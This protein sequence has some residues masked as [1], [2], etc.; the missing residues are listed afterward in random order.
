MKREPLIGKHR[1]ILADPP[2]EY[3]RTR[4][5]KE[6]DSIEKVSSIKKLCSR[7]LHYHTMTLKEM[8]SMRSFI[9]RISMEDSFLFMWSTCPQLI[10]SLEL[11]KAWGYKYKTIAFVWV[12]FKNPEDGLMIKY[13]V[14]HLQLGSYTRSNVE[15]VLIG[16]KGKLKINRKDRGTISQV[17]CT[18]GKRPDHSKKPE[19]VQNRIEKLFDG[20]YI[21][22]FARRKRKGWTTWGNEV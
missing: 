8:K 22:L 5:L 6:I 4:S 21:E 15:Y 3:K 11:M 10:E 12:K 17:V 13:P 9:D 14:P 7:N 19:E 16:K 2:W 1:V 18:Y 20:P